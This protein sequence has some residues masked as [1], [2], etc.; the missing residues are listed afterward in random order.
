MFFLSLPLSVQKGNYVLQGNQEMVPSKGDKATIS[1]KN[2]GANNNAE[3][4]NNGDNGSIN[5]EAVM[6][7]IEVNKSVF[8][9]HVL[10]RKII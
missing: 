3:V 5:K 10:N 7:V 6:R 1:I 2:D 4:V 8:I 9:F